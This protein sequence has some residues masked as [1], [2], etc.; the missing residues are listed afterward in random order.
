M[1]NDLS[2]FISEKGSR[3]SCT[4]EEYPVPNSSRDKRKPFTRKRVIRS[5]ERIGSTIAL[6]SINSSTMRPG[7]IRKRLHI[8]ERLSTKL[9]FTKLFAEMF[10]GNCKLVCP[11]DRENQSRLCSNNR[12]VATSVDANR[13]NHVSRSN[14]ARTCGSERFVASLQLLIERYRQ[15]GSLPFPPGIS[16]KAWKSKL[17]TFDRPMSGSR[18]TAAMLLSKE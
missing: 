18:S 1:T 6:V 5:R 15:A 17:S 9:R 3:T 2:T 4:I 12:S 13:P 16:L 11:K 7:A 8:A 10:T 14:S